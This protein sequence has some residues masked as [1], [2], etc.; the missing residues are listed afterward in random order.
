[1]IIRPS[2]PRDRDAILRL[3]EEN[4]F[5]PRDATTWDA[6]G[7]LAMSAWEDGDLVGAI[8][9][10]PRTLQVGGGQSVPTIHETVVAVRPEF[11]GKGIGSRLQQAILEHR[12]AG[13]VLATVFREDPPSGAYRWYLRNGFA[14]AMHI[15]SWFLDEPQACG[16]STDWNVFDP[17]TSELDWNAV[18]TLWR[19]SKASIGG[20][21]NRRHRP[22]RQ[23]LQCHP[24]RQSYDFRVILCTE[25][26]RF[27]GY[28]LLGIGTMHSQTVRADVLEFFA[29]GGSE[30]SASQLLKCIFECAWRNGLRPVRWPLSVADPLTRDARSA[31]MIARWE[32]DML[33]RKLDNSVQPITDNWCYSGADY[34]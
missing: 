4:G 17:A 29:S 10:E 8:P 21:I 23:W 6:L 33:V 28:A 7:M 34:A 30:Q 3:I 27:S 1:M 24:Y 31:G 16:E 2:E 14:P 12:P 15:V 5:N 13:A 26:N 19:N 11:R 22:L 18:E 20:L 32:F 25:E 9:L